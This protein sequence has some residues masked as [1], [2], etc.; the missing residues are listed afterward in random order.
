LITTAIPKKAT[1]AA[2]PRAELRRPA[3]PFGVADHGETEA[4][5]KDGVG[6]VGEVGEAVAEDVGEHGGLTGDAD[7]VGERHDDGDHEEGFGGTGCDEEF[8]AEREG[9]DDERGGERAEILKGFCRGVQDGVGDAASVYDVTDACRHEDKRDGGE[10]TDD[11]FFESL[12][13]G[14]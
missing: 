7:E 11:A 1:V 12:P 9:I 6:G 2:R 14:A 10:Q 3:N 8:D 5:E 13:N 4:D